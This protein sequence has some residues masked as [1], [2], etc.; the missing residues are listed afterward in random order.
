MPDSFVPGAREYSMLSVLDRFAAVSAV[1]GQR[2]PSHLEILSEESVFSEHLRQVEVYVSVLSTD[3]CTDARHTY[4][5]YKCLSLNICMDGLS[6]YKS[7]SVQFWPIMANIHEMP[8]VP[9]MTVAIFCGMSKPGDLESYLRPL[10]EEL[11]ILKQYGIIIKSRTFSVN[12]RAIIADSP[13]RSFIKGVANFNAK[14]GYLKYLQNFNMIDGVVTS[15]PLHLIDLGVTRKLLL[16]WRNGS[17]GIATKLSA[18]QTKEISES[19]CKIQLPSEIHRA[20]RPIEHLR[21][22]KGRELSN[23]LLY[24]SLVVLK[25]VLCEGAYNHFLLYF[26]AVTMFSSEKYRQNWHVAAKMLEDFVDEFG[27]IYDE[28][29]LTSNV[30]NLLHVYDD[31]EN[32]GVLGTISSYPFENHLQFLKKIVRGAIWN[33]FVLVHRP[34]IQ[35][36]TCV[37]NTQLEKQGKCKYSFCIVQVKDVIDRYCL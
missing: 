27:M 16:G 15:D 9:P 17:L 26:S 22:W 6:L 29:Y 20:L 28:K 13:A 7:S 31:V 4:P 14:N 18:K 1:R 25:D 10:I 12:L 30:H 2:K 35:I 34:K 24:P 33:C 3:P 11:N 19:L 8:E 32:Y 21:H 23:F 36:E 37:V 5:P